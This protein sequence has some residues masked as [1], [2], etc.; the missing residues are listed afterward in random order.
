MLKEGLF[1]RS[2]REDTDFALA[3]IIRIAK[4]RELISF[5]KF[6]LELDWDICSLLNQKQG[7]SLQTCFEL[8]LTRLHQKSLWNR[9]R[10]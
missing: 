4:H 9:M 6:L 5:S 10:I 2:I 7:R 3:A 1:Y 8:L